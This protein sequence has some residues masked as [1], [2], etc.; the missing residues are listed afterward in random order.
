[1]FGR[2]TGLMPYGTHVRR[3]QWLGDASSS[4][5]DGF[6]GGAGN[7][8]VLGGILTFTQYTTWYRN[9]GFVEANAHA[10][11]DQYYPQV[12]R[13]GDANVINTGAGNES[14]VGGWG[15]DTVD[16]G[17]GADVLWGLSGDDILQGGAG[18]DGLRGDTVYLIGAT[19][20]DGHGVFHP[21]VFAKSYTPDWLRHRMSRVVRPR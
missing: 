11:I 20:A 17:D 7:D 8:Y 6:D 3:A 19:I 13:D 4:S 16:G 5:L 9:W 14:V 2:S 1:M 15:N 21:K 10:F 18:D 12:R